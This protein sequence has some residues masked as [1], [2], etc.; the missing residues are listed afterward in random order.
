MIEPFDV[1]AVVRDAPRA[2]SE[3]RWGKQVRGVQVF[4]PAASPK[5]VSRLLEVAWRRRAPRGSAAK[6]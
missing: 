5:L 3:L 6:A 4:L 2:R 1:E